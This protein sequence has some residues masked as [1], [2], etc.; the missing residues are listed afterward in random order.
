MIKSIPV[1]SRNSTLL[2]VVLCFIPPLIYFLVF[3]TV[4]LNINYVA[5][6]DILILGVIP[7]FGDAPLLEKWERLVELFPEHRLVFSRSVILFLHSTFGRLDLVWAMVIANL[8]WAGC[9]VV[10]YK[11]FQKLHLSLWYFVPVMWLWFSIQSFENIFWGVSSLCNFGVLLFV[12]TAFYLAVYHPSRLIYALPVA[13]LATFTYGNGLMSFPIVALVMLLSG[14]RKSF[15]ITIVVMALVAF[16]YFIDFTPI[17]QNLDFKNPDEVKEGVLGF[18]GFIGSIATLD[19]YTAKPT[20]LMTAVVIGAVMIISFIFLFRKQLL[21]L[22]NAAWTNKPFTNKGALFALALALFIMITSLALSYKRIPTDHFEGMFKGRYRMYSVL[23]CISLYFAFL[24]LSRSI[25]VKKSL[26]FSLAISV[27]LNLTIL[28]SN[29]ADTVN[30]RRSAICQEFNARYNADWLGT[31]MFSMDRNHLEMIRSYYDSE[32]PLAEGWKPDHY[33]IAPQFEGNNS[34]DL[35]TDRN[36]YLQ[37]GYSEANFPTEKDYSD[38]GYVILQSDSHVY[39]GHLYQHPV[40]LKTTLRRL[41]YF[42]KGA[43]ASFHRETIQPGTYNIYLLQRVDGKNHFYSTN[44]T[45]VRK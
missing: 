24:S 18:L 39:A 42:S 33:A 3:K 13:I 17:T 21:N 26:V 7:G 8:C 11:A 4:A 28:H 43:I 41:M 38:G 27:L 34:P 14:Q 6:D 25:V 44:K 15:V 37:I 1:L 20:L 30:N 36:E 23:A 22:W 32:D 16:I 35:L 2:A 45:W 12:I 29:F 9:A 40:P 5:F 31:K 10:F 19:A